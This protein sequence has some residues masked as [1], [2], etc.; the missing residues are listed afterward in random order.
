LECCCINIKGGIEM[1]KKI[2]STVI[3]ILAIPSFIIVGWQLFAEYA[4]YFAALL[5]L[6]F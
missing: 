4:S 1:L 6:I 5:K 3:I 2:G